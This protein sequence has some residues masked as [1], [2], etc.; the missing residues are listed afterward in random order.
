MGILAEITCFSVHAYGALIHKK[1]T[2][3]VATINA[4]DMN[5][6]SFHEGAFFLMNIG[7][8]VKKASGEAPDAFML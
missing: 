3:F 7:L 1:V 8:K 6:Q 5:T 4:E 2:V